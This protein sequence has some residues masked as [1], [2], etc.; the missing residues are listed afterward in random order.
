MWH[1]VPLINY[2]YYVTYSPTNK[3]K[4]HILQVK[5]LL[6]F[7]FTQMCH[8]TNLSK[9]LYFSCLCWQ[10]YHHPV[11]LSWNLGTLTSWNPLGHSRPATGL[12]YLKAITIDSSGP[13]YHSAA[14]FCNKLYHQASCCDETPNYCWVY[15]RLLHIRNIPSHWMTVYTWYLHPELSGV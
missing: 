10:P 14:P 5:C 8:N 2:R 4:N 9:R 3:I 12:L 11:P 15:P 7:I 6:K 13:I 1:I